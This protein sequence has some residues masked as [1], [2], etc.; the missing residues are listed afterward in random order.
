MRFR[1]YLLLIFL[2]VIPLS[3]SAHAA[4]VAYAPEESSVVSL[5]PETI[6]IRF[7]ERLE[8]SASSMR[9][10]FPSGHIATLSTHVDAADPRTLVGKYDAPA[11]EEYGTYTLSWQVVSADDGHYTKGAFQFFVGTTTAPLTTRASVE[12]VHSSGYLEATTIFMKLFGE[13]MLLGLFA[14]LALVGRRRIFSD[15]AL[16]ALRLYAERFFIA[17]FIMLGTGAIAYMTLKTHGLAVVQEIGFFD[18]LS[19][20]LRTT[21]GEMTIALL[22]LLPMFYFA[23]KGMISRLVAGESLL[24]RHWGSLVVLLLISYTQARLSHAAASHILPAFSVFM[25]I[26]HMMGKGLWVGGLTALAFVFFPAVAQIGAEGLSR[27]VRTMSVM[28]NNIAALAI[29]LGGVSGAWIVWLHLKSFDH[30]LTTPWGNAFLVLLAFAAL[31][32]LLRLMA[33]LFFERMPRCFNCVRSYTALEML[34]GLAVTFFSAV[35]IITSPPLTHA[36]SY[37]AMTI[38]RGGAMMHLADAGGEKPDLLLTAIDSQGRPILHAQAT[39]MLEN[40]EQHVGPIVVAVR[41]QEGAWKLPAANFSPEG[42]WKIRVT[43]SPPG[44]YDM[45]GRFTIDYPREIENA[46]EAAS[47]P[48]WNTFSWTMLFSAIVAAMF[49]MA[50]YFIARRHSHAMTAESEVVSSSRSVSFWMGQLIA[51]LSFILLAGAILVAHKH[52]ATMSGSHDA[53]GHAVHQM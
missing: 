14:L 24:V 8:E 53:I 36:P 32:L 5:F 15:S 42:I 9:L 3:V 38:D 50:I 48:S 26:P 49:S 16:Y 27:A 19:K 41:E 28:F 29:L 40:E 31:L 4:P 46:R 18:A 17:A 21:A 7:S 1:A 25:N 22:M 6:N 23:A 13:S 12:V 20:F 30:L 52:I 34:T 11:R 44:A 35:I 43:L 33:L 39:I 45:N 51:L 37:T 47:R 2:I 10:F